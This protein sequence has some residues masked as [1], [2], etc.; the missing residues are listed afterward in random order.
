MK[1]GKFPFSFRGIGPPGTR[2]GSF[3]EANGGDEGVENT[4]VLPGAGAIAQHPVKRV[5]VPANQVLRFF[6]PDRSQITGD[7][8]A[9]VGDWFE[10]CG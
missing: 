9:N 6:D 4:W 8:Y 5:R 7:R 10:H 2:G 1:G 3:H